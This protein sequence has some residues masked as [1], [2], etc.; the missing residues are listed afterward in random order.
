M[1]Y[2]ARIHKIIGQ[3]ES[4]ARLSGEGQAGCDKVLQQV[5]AIEG[6]VKSLKRVIIEDSLE[7][8]GG[9]LRP[10]KQTKELLTSIRRYL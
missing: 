9:S 10:H 4:L 8:C 5:N 2:E 3:L 6:G 7:A 1:K